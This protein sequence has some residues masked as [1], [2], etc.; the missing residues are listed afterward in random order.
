M[1]PDR[2]QSHPGRTRDTRDI[3]SVSARVRSGPDYRKID[4]AVS[5]L[6]PSWMDTGPLV[7]RRAVAGRPHGRSAA[8]S[9]PLAITNNLVCSR[10]LSAFDVDG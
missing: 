3:R 5:L 9:M 6:A 2:Y 4:A 7:I 10:W 8:C 1:R